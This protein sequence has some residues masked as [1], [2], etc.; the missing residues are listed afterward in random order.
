MSARLEFFQNIQWGRRHARKKV[1]G[2]GGVGKICVPTILV[3]SIVG[4]EKLFKLLRLDVK[5]E[6]QIKP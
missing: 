6:I 1:P 5:V 3:K 4:S 2:E